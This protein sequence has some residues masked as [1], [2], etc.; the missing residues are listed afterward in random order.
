M[1]IQCYMLLRNSKWD[2]SMKPEICI[3]KYMFIVR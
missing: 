2:V 3:E 1:N